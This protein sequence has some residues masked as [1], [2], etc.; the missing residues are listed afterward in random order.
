[1]HKMVHLP[2]R[3]LL[4][5]LPGHLSLQV[6]SLLR[7]IAEAAHATAC[8]VFFATVSPSSGEGIRSSVL[9]FASDMC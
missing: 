5:L 6:I 2:L 9:A 8:A 7:D 3:A 4:A 1:M